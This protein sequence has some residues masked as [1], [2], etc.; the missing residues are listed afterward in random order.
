M[1]YLVFKNNEV[2]FSGDSLPAFDDDD[3]L[4]ITNNLEEYDPGYDYSVVDGEA[5]QGE[6]REIP[7]PPEE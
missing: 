4:I 3:S 5:V 7:H 6:P 1:I 2:V